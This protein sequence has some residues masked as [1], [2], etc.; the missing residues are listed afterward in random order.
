[1]TSLDYEQTNL[2]N[3]EDQNFTPVLNNFLP[4]SR[5][6]IQNLDNPDDSYE[7]NPSQINNMMQI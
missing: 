1:M 6:S 7:Y 5:G 2:I 3:I 4:E